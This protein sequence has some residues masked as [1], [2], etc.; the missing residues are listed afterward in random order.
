M[1]C[2]IIFFFL[3]Q[4]KHIFWQLHG[5][6][7]LIF[8]LLHPFPQIYSKQYFFD[9][10]ILANWLFPM[11][12]RF[13]CVLQILAQFNLQYENVAIE[14]TPPCDFSHKKVHSRLIGGFAIDASTLS[15]SDLEVVAKALKGDKIYNLWLAMIG[16]R[17]MIVSLDFRYLFTPSDADLKDAT[18]YQLW[19]RAKPRLFADVLQ[20]FSSHAARLGLANINLV[21][22][23][24]ISYKQMYVYVVHAARTK[25][26]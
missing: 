12:D 10:R 26:K 7:H 22:Y 8:L 2:F 6:T 3:F 5:F 20:K 15:K 16:G 23:A 4:V 11:L 13:L 19:F 25:L 1:K 18:Q 21:W 9:H 24:K 14:L 17:V